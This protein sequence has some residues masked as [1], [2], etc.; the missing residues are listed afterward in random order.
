MVVKCERVLSQISDYFDDHLD[1]ALKR[2]ME[3]HFTQ[4]RHCQA[5]LDGLGNVADLYGDENMFTLPAGFHSRL[6]RRLAD[7][8]EGKRVSRASI[9]GEPRGHGRACC[10]SAFCHGARSLRATASCTDESA[11]PAIAAT[12]CGRS[13][14]GQDISRARLPLYAW[15]ISH[16]DA[17]RGYSRGLHSL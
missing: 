1:P 9:A 13:G 3:E 8:V 15:K 11:R 4:C 10:L 17:G 6:R 14:W 5:V 2:A 16:G 12:A 7:Q